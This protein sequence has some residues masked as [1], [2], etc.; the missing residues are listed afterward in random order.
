MHRSD[1]LKQLKTTFP[2]LIEPVNQ[3]NGLLHF[4]MRE[5]RLFTQRAIYAN[6]I[7]TLKRCFALAEKVF[8]LGDNTLKDAIDTSFMEDLEFISEKAQF[9]KAWDLVPAPL[10]T[11]YTNFHGQRTFSD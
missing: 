2:E 1:F 5:F 9:R 4:E 7:D 11:L 10:Q 8:L 6:D 3:Q